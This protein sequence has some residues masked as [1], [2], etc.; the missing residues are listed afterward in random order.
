M[1]SH[2]LHQ[3]LI[4]A[5]WPGQPYPRGA[6]WDGEG[7]N[8]S[9]FSARAEK[10]EL[11]IFDH[12]GRHELQRIEMRERTDEIWH[13]YLPEA[14]P[15]LLYGYRV[16][17]PY[18]PAKGDRFNPHKLL[19]EPYAKHL[20]GSLIWSDAHFGYRVGHAK[21][22]LSF[23]RRDSAAG[24]PKCRVIDPAFTWGDDRPPRTPWHDV[25]IYEAHVRGLTMRHPE[26]PPQLRGTYAGLAT[27]PMIE[28]FKRLGI[29]TV[30]LMPVHAFVDDRTLIEKGLRN[31]WGYNTIG[32]FAPDLRYS[33][34][35]RISE[36]K[37][38]VKTLHSAGIEVILDVVYNH[39]A[40]G[41][42]MGPTLSFRGIDN[43]SYYRLKPDD[44]RYYMDFTGT[45]NT[46]NLQ[47]PRVLQ[48]IMDSLR[49]WVLEMHVDGFRFDL[50]SALAR[51][52]FDVDRLGSFF[53]TIGQDPV[54]SQVKLIAEPWDIGSG[55]YQVGNFPPGWNEWNDKYR[56][57]MRAYWKGDGGLIG[58]FARRFTGSSDLYEASGRK[59][60]ASINFVTAHDG[61]TLQDL[62][63]YNEKHNEAN[64]E[65]NRDGHNDNR[66][67]NCGVEGPTDDPQINTLR[68]RQKRNLIA[69]LLLS[70]G[71]P[72]VVAGD[73][74]SHTQLGNNNP[75]C[76]DSE[77]FWLHWALSEEQERFLDFTAQ[78]IAFRRRHAV[79]SRR[80]FLQADAVTAQGLKEIL[81][82]TPQGQEMTETEW[83]QHF[84]R[85]LG[86][87]L[88]GA[89][90]ERRD[91]QGRAVKDN[92]FLLLF[93]A[94]HEMI[95]FK[96]PE[97]LSDKS[98]WTVLDTAVVDKPFT[99][100]RI[101]PGSEYPLQGR[102]LALLR[103]TAYR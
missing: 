42:Q 37:T 91:R 70:Q 18:D 73:E 48:L 60:H 46:L 7:V 90:I 30:E 9:V 103:E 31:Y 68:A 33:S 47:H 44:P 20:Q 93:N 100:N 41:N 36:F 58:D 79:F 101:E 69:S 57:T 59:P 17:G 74:L 94:H 99:Q 67:W 22:D 29:T 89:A 21:D 83:N 3:P 82:L 86:V 23:D 39:T 102:S 26:V 40:E 19:I 72:M 65:D 92:N 16:H 1:D 6:T 49:Y 84:A 34:V 85:C 25:V 52:L 50:A 61:F 77:P 43:A 88:A 87:Y 63:S 96:L 45:G 2:A 12:T 55:G 97:F 51:E 81:W 66:S 98:W 76:Q 15:G 8:F 32:F 27:A 80:R 10:V 64:G 14:R 24:T 13:C 78:V 38:M 56:D 28:H 4:T 11:C 95:P 54:I 62:V 71:V 75:Y 53:D 35:G 5:V